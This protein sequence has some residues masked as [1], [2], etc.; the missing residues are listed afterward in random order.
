MIKIEKDNLLPWAQKNKKQAGKKINELSNK[1][2]VMFTIYENDLIF[3]SLV[4][5]VLKNNYKKDDKENLYKMIPHYLAVEQKIFI[6]KII[7]IIETDIDSNKYLIINYED[8]K[9][10]Y[11][12]L[13]MVEELKE[14]VRDLMD[15]E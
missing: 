1:D 8:I 5:K 4:E 14:Y 6:N 11:I 7:E 13:K 3:Y 2:D 12:E 15:L 9:I 10:Y